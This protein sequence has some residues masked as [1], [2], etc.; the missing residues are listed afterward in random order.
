MLYRPK[1]P[2]PKPCTVPKERSKI[3]REVFSE[4]GPEDLVFYGQYSTLWSGF[5]RKG[6]ARQALQVSKV[7]YLPVDI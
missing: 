7:L 4:W 1:I 2:I 6:I 3:S 5:F